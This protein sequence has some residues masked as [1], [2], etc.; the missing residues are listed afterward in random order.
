MSLRWFEGFEQYGGVDGGFPPPL[1]LEGAWITYLNH[2]VATHPRTG[3]V[4]MA[5]GSTGDGYAR[6]SLGRDCSTVGVG[7]GFYMAAAP[8]AV[9]KGVVGG[10]HRTCIIQILDVNLVEQICV[11]SGTTGRLQVFCGLTLLAE[12]TLEIVAGSWNH[13]EVKVVF[14]GSA[15]VVLLHVNGKEWINIT[16]QNTVAPGATGFGSQIAFGVPGGS[17]SIFNDFLYWDDIFVY[18]EQTGGVHDI[19]GQYGVY[20]LKPNADDGTH[21]DWTLT[22]GTHGYA[23]I[24]EVPPDDDLNFIFTGTL[25]NRSD[26]GVE[27]LPANIVSVA[28]VMPVARLRKTDTGDASV[29]I[30][31]NSAGT[32]SYSADTPITTS[33]TYYQPKVLE[34]DPNTSAAW[35]PVNVNAALLT[36]KRVA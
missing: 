19:L 9:D 31:V 24:N 2:L 12:S 20:Q 27:P 32:A 22:S 7:C 34:K 11:T 8:V 10:V 23:L 35:D 15:G 29:D 13:I 6:R 36:I 3:I 16:D 21:H 33:W 30:G 1:P 25:T 18:D 4:C 17:S 5:T 26:F 14:D 28:A